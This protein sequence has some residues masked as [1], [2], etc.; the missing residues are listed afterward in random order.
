MSFSNFGVC[1]T[2]NKAVGKCRDNSYV[3]IGKPEY[4][5]IDCGLNNNLAY[6]DAQYS[7]AS[8]EYYKL[9]ALQ[10]KFK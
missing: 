9:K 3:Y 10:E 7:Q 2:C 4:T 8:D 1:D 6:A 5:C